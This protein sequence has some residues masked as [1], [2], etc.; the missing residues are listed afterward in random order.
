MI[1]EFT[2]AAESWDKPRRIVTR[3]EYGA[4]GTN[5]R[6][7]VTNLDDRSHRAV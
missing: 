3:L 7:V 5:P 1:D 6:F 2:Y 4:Q